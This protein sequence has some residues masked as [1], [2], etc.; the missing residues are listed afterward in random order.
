MHKR[1]L[2]GPLLETHQKYS[3]ESEVIFVDGGLNFKDQVS[4]PKTS[5]IGDGDSSDKKP[6]NLLSTNKDR[7]DL[8]YALNKSSKAKTYE[9]YGFWGKDFDHHLFN[10]GEAYQ[11]LHENSSI[12]KI[13]F[14]YKTKNILSIYQ[15]GKFQFELNSEF[16]LG[17]LMENLIELDGNLTYQGTIRL[18]ALSSQGLHNKAAGKFSIKATKPFLLFYKDE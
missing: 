7:S 5:S 6:E 9:L 13:D 15:K 12:E 4:A 10:I 18:I 8:Y 17:S 1:I 2:I 16:S 11:F 14:F 3:F